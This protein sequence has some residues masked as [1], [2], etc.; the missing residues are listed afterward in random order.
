MFTVPAIRIGEAIHH[1]SLTVF[2]LFAEPH[3]QV[4]YLLSDEAIKTGKVTVQEVSEGGSVPD[5]LVEN[6]GDTR[7]L[8]LEG[9]ELVGA[10]QNRILNTSVLLPA[11]SKTRIPV[12]CVER[13]RWSYKSRHF[14]SDGRHSPSKLRHALK[15]SVTESL[16]SGT[17]HRSDQGRVWE[18]VDKQQATLGVSSDTASMSDSF[19]S[20]Q[21]LIDD[22]AD[23]FQY[24]EGAAG[25]AVAIGDKIVA[26]DLFDNAATCQK[27]WRRLLSGFIL[28]TMEPTVAG[29]GQVTQPA[30][31]GTLAALRNSS[32]EKV[33]PVG[34]G[35]EYRV[36]LNDGTQASALAFGDALVHGSLL[37]GA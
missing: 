25:M 23:Q 36:K 29:T 16:H 13:G 35:E 22:Y 24:P 6:S 2:P 8:F 4:D 1:K 7:V 31:E 32:W 10:K 3:G 15:Q 26:V 11:R 14:G 30:V 37:T 21:P 9:E 27:V 18:E 33:Q 28:D 19:I 12:S 34:D 17:G 20:H 5:L